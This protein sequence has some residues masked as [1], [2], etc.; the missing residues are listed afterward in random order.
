M[1]NENFNAPRESED[2]T[3]PFEVVEVIAK[4]SGKSLEEIESITFEIVFTSDEF[5]FDKK[6]KCYEYKG[7]GVSIR[8]PC[9]D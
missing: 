9:K 5:S 6:K 8:V 3:L 7:N 1:E 4:A 2:E